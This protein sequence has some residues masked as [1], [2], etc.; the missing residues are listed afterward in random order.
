LPAAVAGDKHICAFPGLPPHPP[1]IFPPG[2]GSKTVFIGG[3]P[4]SAWV[5]YLP[6][7]HRFSVVR[8]T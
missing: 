3:D 2:T 8:K 5:I 1:N 6:A 4:L 7:A